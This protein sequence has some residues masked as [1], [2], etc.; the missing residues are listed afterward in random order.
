MQPKTKIKVGPH[1]GGD[2]KDSAKEAES[3]I[4]PIEQWDQ[5]AFRLI[6]Q[7]LAPKGYS[8][9]A[10]GPWKGKVK[11]NIE[12]LPK[13]TV[14]NCQKIS[15]QLI[16]TF[17]AKALWQLKARLAKCE[18]E[19]QKAIRLRHAAYFWQFKKKRLEQRVYEHYRDQS[20]LL[21]I[22]INEIENIGIK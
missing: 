22:L 15:A 12:F 11:S 9:I 20:G 6:Q 1:S 8:Q 5:V 7:E 21:Q 14:Q 16:R 4:S 10:R 19:Q 18:E 2:K 17:R 3:Q 13:Q